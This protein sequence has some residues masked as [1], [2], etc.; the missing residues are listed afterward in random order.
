MKKKKVYFN[1]KNSKISTKSAVANLHPLCSLTSLS[2]EFMEIM[3]KEEEGWMKA[4]HFGF[5]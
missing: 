1:L 5:L 4:C 3:E 2:S